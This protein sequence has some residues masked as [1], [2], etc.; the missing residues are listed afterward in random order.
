MIHETTLLN[1]D[2]DFTNKPE[3]I[4]NQ[5]VSKEFVSSSDIKTNLRKYMDID[6]ITE[7]LR[8]DHK[9]M[10]QMTNSATQNLSYYQRLLDKG[11][12]V[13]KKFSFVTISSHHNLYS[14]GGHSEY[15]LKN[16]LHDYE[17]H[18]AFVYMFKKKY[19]DTMT[20]VYPD[21]F[22]PEQVDMHFKGMDYVKKN[23]YH[24][25][26]INQGLRLVVKA[27]KWSDFKTSQYKWK[28]LTIVTNQHTANYKPED[29]FKL[30]N[31]IF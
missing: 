20:W 11:I 10:G 18:Q 13:P 29:L 16:E 8:F 6:E 25:V 7:K 4:G 28:A 23:G 2:I 26:S 12:F 21:Y 15:E 3:L 27:I 5:Y 1:I 24:M 31:L 17:P 30:K 19:I 14:F 9:Y 22:T